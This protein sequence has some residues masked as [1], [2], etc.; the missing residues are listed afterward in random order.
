MAVYKSE[1]LKS[2]TGNHLKIGIFAFQDIKACW[3]HNSKGIFIDLIQEH[4]SDIT[5]HFSFGYDSHVGTTSIEEHKID[6]VIEFVDKS[7]P[8]RSL[9]V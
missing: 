2:I 7:V 8:S 1:R 4:L 9:F 3:N 6:A 5:D